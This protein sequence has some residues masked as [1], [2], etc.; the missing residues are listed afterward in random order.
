M[1]LNSDFSSIFT[2]KHLLNNQYY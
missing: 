1:K 2:G